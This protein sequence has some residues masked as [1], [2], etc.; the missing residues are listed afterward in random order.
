VWWI[1]SVPLTNPHLMT[2]RERFE[3]TSR[4]FER[5]SIDEI[6]SAVNQL[7]RI[8][9]RLMTDRAE[10]DR[11]TEGTILETGYLALEDLRRAVNS[12]ENYGK[13]LERHPNDPNH[14]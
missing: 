5:M 14:S 8:G 7:R 3:M 1:G 9:M 12:L 4:E 10:T 11:R 13:E 2:F 6:K